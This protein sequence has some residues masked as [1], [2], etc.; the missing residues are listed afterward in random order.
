MKYWI[1]DAFAKEKFKRNP[2][3]VMLVEEFPTHMQKIAAEF[4]LSET[5]FVKYV[6]SNKYHIRWCTPTMEV[7]LCGHGTLAAAHVLFN[8]MNIKFESIDLDSL[9]GTLKVTR[10][11]QS[12][13]QLDFP[14][15]PIETKLDIS[16][17]LS[18]F[19]N[20]TV[21]EVYNVLDDVMIVL[22]EESDV[23]H[24]QPNFDLMK[25]FEYG[26]IMITAPSQ[27]YDFVSRYFCPREGINED[28]VTG[29]AHCKLADYW[30]KRLNKTSFRVFQASHRG[31]ELELNIHNDRVLISGQAIVTA[32]GDFYDTQ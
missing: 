19:T 10:V 18:L 32:A 22:Q 9:S 8:E 28:P 5:S 16:R 11:S 3:A 26:G 20:E 31:G 21:C 13:Y 2:A 23:L 30:S 25:T 7:P 1:V 6:D 4:N 12:K 14:L 17:F 15:Q 29:S 24:Y 27:S